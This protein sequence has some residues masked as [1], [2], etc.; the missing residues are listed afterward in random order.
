MVPV[1]GLLVLM[2]MAQELDPLMV[3][4]AGA[5]EAALGE[6]RGYWVG[7][8]GRG[9]TYRFGGSTACS[10]RWTSAAG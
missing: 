2:V 8:Q 5:A 7:A 6:L 10:H 4:G 1:S 3:A 9:I